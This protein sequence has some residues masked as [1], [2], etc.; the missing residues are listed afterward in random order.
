[1]YNRYGVVD[2]VVYADILV[3]LN[4]IINYFLLLSVS[5][6]IRKDPA[7]WRMVL[8]AFLGAASSLYIFLP[9]LSICL[10]GFIKLSV[11]VIMSLVAFGFKGIKTFLKNILLLFGVTVAYGG[12]MYAVWL[13]FKPRGM[14]INNSVVYF[15]ISVSALLGFTVLG[16]IIFSLLFKIFSRCAPLAS[17]CD[18]TVFTNG[19]S[20][21]LSGIVDTGNSIEDIFSQGEIIIC[22]EAVKDKLFGSCDIKGNTALKNRYRLLPCST[23]S[24]T[25][26]LEGVRCDKAVVTAGK[27]IITLKKPILA[28]SKTELQDS[29]AII[30]PNILG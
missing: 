6:I 20:V 1:M 28:F 23:V 4:L 19:K 24:G 16:Y 18:V 22:G 14:V 11:C 26:L 10:E 5:K 9:P 25:D 29:E 7:V 21:T 2:L 12:I 17:R 15:D 30:N 8:S 27:Q 3:F 13:L